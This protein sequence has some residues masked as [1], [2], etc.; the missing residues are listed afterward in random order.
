MTKTL[1]MRQRNIIRR[2]N[3]DLMYEQNFFFFS[4]CSRR[5]THTPNREQMQIRALCHRHDYLNISDG[6]L[7]LQH[8]SYGTMRIMK[9]HVD[10]FELDFFLSTPFCAHFIHMILFCFG[11]L[12]HHLKCDF[13]VIF[14]ASLF[15][16]V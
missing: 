11:I 4:T 6:N 14:S 13:A 7:L 5:S 8:L 16:L 15:P 10:E 1:I 12:C 9:R 3:H 2:S